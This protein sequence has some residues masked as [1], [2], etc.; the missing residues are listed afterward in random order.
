MKWEVNNMTFN[1]TLVILLIAVPLAAAF[2]G[3]LIKKISKLFLAVAVGFNVGAAL[4][5]AIEYVK[6]II[7][8][9]GGFKPPFGISLVL[10]EYALIGILLLNIVF[11]LIAVVSCKY[12]KKYEVVLSVAL[13]ALNGII[14]TGDLFN[15]FVFM[16]I[17]AITAYILTTMNKGFKY[18]FNYLVLGTLGSG[19]FL[20]G[21]AILY[22]MFGSLNIQHIQGLQMSL[23]YP[24]AKSLALPLV[25][26]FVGLSV[27][28][29]L[30]PFGGWVKGVLK[31]A[32][33]LVGALIA[34]AFATA[35]LFAFGRLMNSIFVLT[36]G[37]KIAL[38]VVAVATLVLA[39]F[40]A[41]SKRN[42]REILL[43][44][45]IAQ[46]GLAVALFLHGLT[47][48]AVLVII[49]NVVSKLVLFTISAKIADDNGTDKLSELKGIFVKNKL[50]GFGFS[51][52]AMSLIGLPLFFGF[53][54][55]VNALT[56]LFAIDNI[57]LPLVILLVSVVEGA[58]VVRILTTLWNTGDEGELAKANDA[59][60]YKL[61]NKVRLVIII[62]IVAIVIIAGGIIPIVHMEDFMNFDVFSFLAT[63]MGGV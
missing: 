46:S 23:S 41:F 19:L 3:V 13:A 2:L 54:A 44:S 61:T 55:K 35:V 33:P 27:E 21:I 40:S 1:S 63:G 12:I 43:F 25:L 15:L 52:A 5:L 47:N 59:K 6:P 30:L 42:L 56:A 58:Y 48:A 38:A 49:N 60:T 20:F 62:M 9:V 36:D 28:A 4:I 14:L 17:A 24:I 16:E 8:T 32:N 18:T 26:I 31:N 45:S 53:V 22:N 7:Y 37:L 50:L 29:K 39:E 11:A 10:D 51:V 34:S 57:W